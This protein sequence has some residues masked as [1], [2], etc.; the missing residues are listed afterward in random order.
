MLSRCW[1]N[2]VVGILATLLYGAAPAIASEAAGPANIPV[3][4]ILPLQSSAFGR[5]ADSVRQGVLAAAKLDHSSPLAITVYPTADDPASALA[6][7]QQATQEG[8]RLII[9]PLTRNGVTRIAQHMQPGTRVLALNLPEGDGP[10]PEDLYTFSLQVETEARQIARLAFADGRRTALMVTEA[11]LLAR[12]MHAAFADEFV[13]Q[14]GKVVAQF[15]FSTSA[16][17]LVA[18]RESVASGHADAVFLALEAQ[19]ARLVRP[20]VDGP[21]QVYATSASMLMPGPRA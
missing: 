5:F 12:R 8:S 16:A 9:G 14:G 21:T 1:Q 17:D 6:A 11:S 2:T 15:A 7:Y 18:L 3:A 4:L 10:L 20:Y 19:R 13:R